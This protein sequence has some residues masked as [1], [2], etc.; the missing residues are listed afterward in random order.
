MPPNY[1]DFTSILEI[2]TIK[3]MEYVN[4]LSTL[5]WEI[6]ADIEIIGNFVRS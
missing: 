6:F 1:Y 3:K 5:K 2:T 4:R